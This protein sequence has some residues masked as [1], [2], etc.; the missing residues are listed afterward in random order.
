MI[1]KIKKIGW[2]AGGGGVGLNFSG[3][4]FQALTRMSSRRHPH[5]FFFVIFF[6]RR[7]LYF[8]SR[9]DGGAAWV[10]QCR[11]IYGSRGGELL[12]E[13][14]PVTSLTVDGSAG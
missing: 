5:F 11:G 14:R 7:T 13:M 4:I 1:R 9:L 2:G 8:Q 6:S 3:H 10:A 12:T